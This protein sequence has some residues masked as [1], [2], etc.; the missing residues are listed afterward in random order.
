MYF[1]RADLMTRNLNGRIEVLTPLLQENLCNNV[2]NQIVIPQLK[3]NI[4]AWVMNSDGSYTKL[5]PKKD[6]T[7]YD[8]QEEIAKKL[9][10]MKK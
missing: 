7:V 8:S 10:L 2:M 4:H 5:Q 9:N 6:E 1:G 3:D